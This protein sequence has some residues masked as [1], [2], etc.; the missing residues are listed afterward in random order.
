M[1]A[2]M[3]ILVCL[4]MAWLTGCTLD[5]QTNTKVHIFNPFYRPGGNPTYAPVVKQTTLTPENMQ[6]WR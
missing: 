5:R 4:A 6:G 1:K 3:I 2:L